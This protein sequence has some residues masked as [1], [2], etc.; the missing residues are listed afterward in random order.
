MCN[1]EQITLGYS[2]ATKDIV[3]IGDG[4]HNVRIIDQE[5]F[6]VLEQVTHGRPEIK[7]NVRGRNYIARVEEC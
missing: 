6:D 7:F 2:P 1:L 3:M 5:F 4:L